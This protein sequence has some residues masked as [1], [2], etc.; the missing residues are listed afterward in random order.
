MEDDF[1]ALIG[2]TEVSVELTYQAFSTQ[3]T[4][5]PT[6][7]KRTSTFTN[8]VIRAFRAPLGIREINQSGGQYQMG[9]VRYLIAVADVEKPQKNDQIREGTETREVVSSLSDAIGGGSI[10]HSIV[11]RQLG[12]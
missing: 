1:A 9:D 2:D 10:F 6:T 8:K 12:K 3:G 7:A 5:S 11:A 4:Y